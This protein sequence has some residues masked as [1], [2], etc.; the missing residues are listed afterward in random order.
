MKN[1]R[2]FLKL[3]GAGAV[4]A[5]A[6]SLPFQMACSRNS[7]KSNEEK[8]QYNIGMAG[9]SFFKLTF[10]K[11][12]EIMNRVNVKNM[13]LKDN[14]LSLDSDEETIKNV[15]GSFR[16]AGINV[17]AAG[18]ITMS[19]ESEVLR[20]FN[21][22]K[23]AGI[24]MIVGSPSPELLPIVEKKVK[25]TGIRVAI[26]NH[27]PDNQAFITATDIWEK[28]KDLDKGIGI[29]MDIGHT[30]RAGH[31]PV[32]DFMKYYPRIYDVHIKDVT[33]AAKEGKTIEMGRGIID[34]PAFVSALKK[35]GYAGMCSLEF[36]KDMDDPL[37]GIAESIGY[38]KGVSACR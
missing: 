9:Y 18:V 31:D 30:T 33:A 38:F 7:E 34:I 29:C 22:V 4:A 2:D 5:G 11:A 37:A 27:G 35:V 6:S 10:D 20:A 19:K 17:Y 28:I 15:M 8:Q 13:S 14:F 25:E 36:E 1:R 16:Q 26:H 12:I 3:A 32:A 21:Y 23:T 24:G